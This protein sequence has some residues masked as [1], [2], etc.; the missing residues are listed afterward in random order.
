MSISFSA[1]LLWWFP[2][3]CFPSF[4]A[5]SYRFPWCFLMF[6]QVFIHFP[7]VFLLF[8]L[9]VSPVSDFGFRVKQHQWILFQFFY[10][11]FCTCISPFSW[12][13][14]QSQLRKTHLKIVI[15]PVI[16]M[17]LFAWKLINSLKRVILYDIYLTTINY[18]NS[19]L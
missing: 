17:L 16:Y 4:L 7:C 9:S 11:G 8:P 1:W 10:G 2:P 15:K 14:Q 13:T 3:C 19:S 6:S 5:I 18:Q 12:I